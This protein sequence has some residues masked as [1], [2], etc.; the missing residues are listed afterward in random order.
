MTAG[1]ALRRGWRL[2]RMSGDEWRLLL[3]AVWLLAAARR[4]LQRMAPLPLRRT[5][6]EATPRR[7]SPGR[8]PDTQVA[9][10][11]ARASR[12]VPRTTCLCRALA[13]ETML[14]ARGAEAEMRLGVRREASGGLI[15]HA[16]VETPTATFF[17]DPTERTVPLPHFR[18]A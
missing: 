14:R 9:V 6:E 1:R 12:L 8:L 5:L 18:T 2:V 17:A 16:W 3:E 7:G 10:A 15:A 13:L 4:R 11:V